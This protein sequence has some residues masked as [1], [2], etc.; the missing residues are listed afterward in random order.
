MSLGA[1]TPRSPL[2][3]C[4]FSPTFRDTL[5]KNWCRTPST[6]ALCSHQRSQTHVRKIESAHP[7]LAPY[8][9][10][11][12]HGHHL[13]GASPV[14]FPAMCPTT[15]SPGR[16]WDGSPLRPPHRPRALRVAT[17]SPS[18]LLRSAQP[19]S[20]RDCGNR[21]DWYTRT[22]HEPI[23]LH[24]HEVA[25][26]AVP[27]RCRW[28]VSSGIAHPAHDGTHWCRIPHPLLCPAQPTSA[29]LSPQLT[30]LRRRLTLRTRR[31]LDT[32]A[33]T[34]QPTK[35]PPAPLMSARPTSSAAPVLPLPRPAPPRRHP[36]RRTDPPAPPL[37]PPRPHPARTSRHLDTHDSHTLPRTTRPSRNRDG[38]LR[39]G[40]PALHRTAALAIPALLP[41]RCRLTRRGPGSRRVGGLRPAA[42]PR[43]HAPPPAHRGPARGRRM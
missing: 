35:P 14:T 16:R 13:S 36:L 18:R 6:L 2:E 24:P 22:N 43:A 23:S 17:D 21:I 8:A 7:T 27:D 9:G 19:G 37:H 26:V 30:E 20:C 12:R 42:P 25:A 41:P 31:L 1:D 38:R 39:P 28:H 34:P 32:G 15:A 11:T 5:I 4:R 40:P 10:L 3:C 29:A 33:F